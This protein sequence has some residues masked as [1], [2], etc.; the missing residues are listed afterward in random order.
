[1][2]WWVNLVMIN[3]IIPLIL[4]GFGLKVGLFAFNAPLII[5]SNEPS[6]WQF[7]LDPSTITKEQ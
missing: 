5:N 3:R 7:P 2:A 1:M 4:L 6:I